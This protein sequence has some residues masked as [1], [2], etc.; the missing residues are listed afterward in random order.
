MKKVKI[1]KNVDELEI[2]IGLENKYYELYNKK[3]KEIA[4]KWCKENNLE[5]EE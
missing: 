2:E 3:L 1:Q 5:Y 4:I